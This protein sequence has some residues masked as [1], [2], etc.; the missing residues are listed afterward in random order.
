MPGP[1]PLLE[2]AGHLLG[3]QCVLAELLQA[4]AIQI[5]AEAPQLPQQLPVGQVLGVRP[6]RPAAALDHPAGHLAGARFLSVDPVNSDPGQLHTFL[7]TSSAGPASRHD[8]VPPEELTLSSGAQP[9][10]LRRGRDI[11]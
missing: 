5:Q 4:A 3:G 7:A 10:R 11:T 2:G 1:A 6:Q 9:A 8:L